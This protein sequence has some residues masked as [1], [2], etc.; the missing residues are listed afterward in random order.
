MTEPRPLLVELT[1][2]VKTYDTDF[3]GIVHNMVYIRWLEDLRLEILAAHFPMEDQLAANRGPILVKTEVTY[4][5]PLRL[6]DEP[7]G[8]MWVSRLGRVRWEVQA[9]IVLDDQVAATAMQNG[10][11]AD[12]AD[13]RPVRVPEDLRAKWLHE[14]RN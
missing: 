14:S 5:G 6:F 3:A 11:F 4:Q 7:V 10:F 13:L 2:K 1:F 9:E 8:R 12:L